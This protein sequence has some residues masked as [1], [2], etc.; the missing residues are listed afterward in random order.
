MPEQNVIILER[1]LFALFLD[2]NYGICAITNFDMAVRKLRAIFNPQL[3][4]HVC[5]YGEQ[6]DFLFFFSKS[7]LKFIPQFCECILLCIMTGLILFGWEKIVNKIGYL[8]W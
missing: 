3:Q 1:L 5:P 7:F 6:I 2:V 4:Q 8:M